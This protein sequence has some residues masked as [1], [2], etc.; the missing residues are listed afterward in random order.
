MKHP[1]SKIFI[2]LFTIVNLFVLGTISDRLNEHRF[3][4]IW[5]L[6]ITNI[7][8]WL[9][10]F[11]FILN[12]YLKGNSEKKKE[13]LNIYTPSPLKSCITPSIIILSIAYIGILINF[14]QS[15]DDLLI[16]AMIFLLLIFNNVPTI[17]ILFLIFLSRFLNKN[18]FL[19]LIKYLLAVVAFIY[20]LFH[21][22]FMFFIN[23]FIFCGSDCTKP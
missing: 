20:T 22:F 15:M 1:I 17:L 6:I 19:K 13:T 8:I 14:Y 9:M 21:L 18:I 3:Y 10:Y 16:L 2:V 5:V 7:Y 11:L 12:K 4:S 23:F